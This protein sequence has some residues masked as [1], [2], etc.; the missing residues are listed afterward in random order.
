MTT[1]KTIEAITILQKHHSINVTMNKV[2]KDQNVS[3]AAKL[4]IHECSHSAIKDL[5]DAGYS[6]FMNSEH[7]GP[8]VDHIR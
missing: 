2:G 5:I 1:E 6:V 4:V 3:T 8:W 7:K